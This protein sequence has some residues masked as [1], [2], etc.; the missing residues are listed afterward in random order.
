MKISW[1]IN[2][3]GKNI[4]VIGEDRETTT[5]AYDENSWGSNHNYDLVTVNN[6]EDIDATLLKNFKLTGQMSDPQKLEM[7]FEK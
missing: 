2:I 1:N 7:D 3:N 5:I 4:S 6:G